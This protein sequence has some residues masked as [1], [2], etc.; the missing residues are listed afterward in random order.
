MATNYAVQITGRRHEIMEAAGMNIAL[1]VMLL[2]V[3]MTL[4]NQA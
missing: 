1:L 3:I 4:V 2:I